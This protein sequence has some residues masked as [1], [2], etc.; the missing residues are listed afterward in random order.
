MANSITIIGNLVEPPEFKKT[1]EGTDMCKFRIA[2]DNYGQDVMFWSCVVFDES[3]LR[4][5][6]K[7]K[8]GSKMMVVAQLKGWRDDD[9]KTRQPSAKVFSASFMSGGKK[10][11]DEGGDRGRGGDLPF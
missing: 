3:P 4:P 9:D 7:A 8:K 5:L 1:S 6:R 10:P 2:D 11:D